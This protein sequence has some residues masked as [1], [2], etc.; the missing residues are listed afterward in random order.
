[1]TVLW[2]I[3]VVVWFRLLSIVVEFVEF[4]MVVVERV[5]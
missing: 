2:M 4:A 3:F 5:R 1:V